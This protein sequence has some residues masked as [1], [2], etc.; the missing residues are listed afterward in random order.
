MAENRFKVII[1]DGYEDN[2]KDF[3]ALAAEG[4]D[5][6]SA[7]G[8]NILQIVEREAPVDAIWFRDKPVSDKE[9]ECFAGAG[10][11]V[12]GRQGIGLDHISKQKATEL[13]IWIVNLPDYGPRDVSDHAIFMAGCLLRGIASTDRIIR[14]GEGF[15]KIPPRAGAQLRSSNCTVGIIGLG[16]VGTITAQTL[17]RGFEIS[18]DQI[19]GVDPWCDHSVFRDLGIEQVD[20]ETVC[21]N[22]DLIFL[23]A[24]LYEETFHLI[25]EEQFSWM[26]STAYLINDA[27]GGLINEADLV[28]ALQTGQLAGAALD[29]YEE[30]PIAVDS[31]LLELDN[32]ILTAH[33]AYFS[34]TSH[35]VQP[36]LLAKAIVSACRREPPRSIGNPQVLCNEP[37]FGDWARQAIPHMKWQLRRLAHLGEIPDFD[38]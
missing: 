26:K 27:R 37:W 13:G 4:A 22:S 33:Q 17:H 30:E 15:P 29:V 10:V 5:G 23:H 34:V 9:L 36:V 1:R 2:A 31:P 20:L 38:C 3:A 8:E 7:I 14:R 18:T 25:A 32:T 16:T 24:P 12:M 11:R 19:L 28:V 35:Q 21:R 6:S